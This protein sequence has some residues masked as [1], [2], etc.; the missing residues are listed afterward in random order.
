MC[1]LTY[2]V[3]EDDG[4]H[5]GDSHGDQGGALPGA[6]LGRLLE[7]ES[8][9]GQA[10]SGQRARRRGIK[11]PRRHGVTR[12][13]CTKERRCPRARL[14]KKVPV[15]QERGRTCEHHNLHTATC[16]RATVAWRGR[17][18]QY[19]GSDRKEPGYIIISCIILTLEEV[20]KEPHKNNHLPLALLQLGFC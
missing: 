14:K 4:Q 13:C 10:V 18:R 5:H 1:R 17:A 2:T 15:E 3:A 9:S 8:S 12:G 6:V 11:R 7:L 19:L 20:K 16:V